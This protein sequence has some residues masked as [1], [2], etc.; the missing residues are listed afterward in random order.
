MMTINGEKVWIPRR[1]QD[2]VAGLRRMGIL[3]VAGTPLN[4]V[5]KDELLRLYCREKALMVRRQQWERRNT[6][7]DAVPQQQVDE[8]DEQ[9]A[10]FA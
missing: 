5:P 4:Q 7:G 8:G 3:R 6:T 1:R 2:L 9:L 10:L